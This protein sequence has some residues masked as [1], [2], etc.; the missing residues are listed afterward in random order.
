ML[1]EE[2]KNK[3]KILFSE[4]KYEEVIETSERFS[5]PEDRPA[6][7]INIIGI[8]YFLK[9]NR[10]E[11]DIKTALSFFELTYLKDKNTIHGL[12]GLKNLILMGIK[13]SI[14]FKNLSN[15][16]IKA[17]NYFNDAIKYFEN[18]EEFLNAGLA[19]S[20]HLLD[21]KMQKNIIHKVLDSKN[22][23][24]SLRGQSL[25][26]KNY[27]FDNS[28]KDY[29]VYAKNNS[30]YYSKLQVK[31]VNEIQNLKSDKINLG[32]VSC[33]IL[34][35][36]STTF[37][38]KDTIRYLDKSK[39]KIFIFS[40]AKKDYDDTSQN[41][42]RNIADEWF[43]LKNSNNQE[44]VELIQK[45]KIN[46]LFDLM[47]YTASERLEIFNSR[48]APVQISWLAYLNTTGLDTIDYLLVDN[49]LVKS[50]ENNLYA[51][52]I[53]KLPDIWNAHAGFT[54]E[55]KY[56]ELPFLKNKNFTFGSLNNFRKIS[57][58]T[59]YVWSEILKKVPNSNLILKSADFCSDEILM[60]KFKI[61]GVDNR[62][63]ILNKIDFIKKEDHLNVY[64]KIDLCLD[65]FPHN[66]VT[67]T[68]EA[69]WMG[70]PVIVLKGKN[71]CSRCGES[72]IKNTKIDGLIAED[73][74]DYIS[75]AIHLSK[76]IKILTQIRENL[77]HSV[78]SSPLFDTK[79]FSKNFNNT[80]L[81]IYKET[82]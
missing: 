1:T 22:S 79:T 68:F 9:E 31:N 74:N 25:F 53:L 67:T 41:E 14:E 26:M 8:S 54:Y 73:L 78:L 55:R 77:Y 38:L 29:L 76:D 11:N 47:G 56:N 51:E 45:K 60:N 30:K 17:K 52:K 59:V 18:N 24:K 43:D 12:N 75:K 7:L 70:V 21:I 23:S 5:S 42:L 27:Y 39:F 80:L 32:F 33:D 44:V 61:E 6:G 66:G 50:N 10:N 3:I 62:V 4:K 35:N 58:E 81:Q 49:N 57:D 34:R 71:F 2:I 20:L 19:L 16:L 65:T 13:A 15:F 48:V 28:Q 40:I 36:H 82:N 69:L 63:K 46:I 37:F 64:Q 72:I